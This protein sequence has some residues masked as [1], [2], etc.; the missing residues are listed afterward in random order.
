MVGGE[1]TK[2]CSGVLLDSETER[3]CT[4]QTSLKPGHEQAWIGIYTKECCAHLNPAESPTRPLVRSTLEVNPIS[5]NIFGMNSELMTYSQK[6]G[7]LRL[8]LC[9]REHRAIW[10]EEGVRRLP[11]NYY[12]KSRVKTPVGT[13]L[14]SL[15]RL[16]FY[17]CAQGNSVP[18]P[19]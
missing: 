10:H 2:G 13:V 8:R 19:F 6:T 12:I 15:E 16:R 1:R 3:L 17:Y 4:S 9:K 11:F 14:P 18:V 5:N 7:L